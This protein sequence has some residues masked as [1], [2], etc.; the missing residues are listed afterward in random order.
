MVHS[1]NLPYIFI[2]RFTLF[3]IQAEQVEQPV[4]GT[5]KAT[6]ISHPAAVALMEKKVSAC[7]QTVYEQGVL[8]HL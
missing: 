1:G 4:T 6:S 3:F 8:L 7:M 5:E 2:D